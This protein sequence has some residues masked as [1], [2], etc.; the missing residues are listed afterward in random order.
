MCNYNLG[1]LY[2]WWSS[3]FDRLIHGHGRSLL[4]QCFQSIHWSWKEAVKCGRQWQT[5]ER[6]EFVRKSLVKKMNK[7]WQKGSLLPRD[8]CWTWCM[9]TKSPMNWTASRVGSKSSWSGL[10]STGDCLLPRLQRDHSG[11]ITPQ[12]SGPENK[13]IFCQKD[14]YCMRQHFRQD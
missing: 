5:K 8:S 4:F 2:S 10:M 3:I 1:V 14:S 9:L 13:Q 7:E 12:Y 11:L 6:E